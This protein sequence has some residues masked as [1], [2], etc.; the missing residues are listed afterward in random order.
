MK[1]IIALDIDG[2]LTGPDH[3]IDPEVLHYLESLFHQGWKM[4]FITGRPYAWSAASLEAIPF[5]YFL[6]IHNGAYILSMPD[7]MIAARY[8]LDQETIVKLVSI[9]EQHQTGLIIYGELQEGEPIYFTRAKFDPATL[10][11]FQIRSSVSKEN[12]K[13]ITS[14]EEIP[15]KTFATVKYFVDSEKADKIA[16]SI[17]EQ[18]KLSSSIIQD[19][20]D[21]S[22]S[23]LQVTHPLANKGDALENFSKI[24]GWSGIRI[25]AGNDLNDFPM[26][27]KA[28]IT[29]AM[30]ESPLLLRQM[31]T[32]IAP[33]VENLGLMTA[34][35][36]AISMHETRKIR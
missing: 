12:W 5:P 27:Q 21:P 1:G 14:L 7:R 15:I 19:P 24:C 17:G 25:A 16:D 2:T 28:Q 30:Q 34:L 10:A 36:S 35:K 11:F 8:L 9:A 23:L 13:S 6:A 31:A 3:Q 26:F 22:Y 29:I 4:I 32:I 18:F 33:P 20:I